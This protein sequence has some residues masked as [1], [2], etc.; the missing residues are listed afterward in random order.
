[1]KIQ[2]NAD[3]SDYS[4]GVAYAFSISEPVEDVDSFKLDLLN[5]IS[6]NEVN[7]EESFCRMVPNIASKN[8][9]TTVDCVLESAMDTSFEFTPIGPY[10]MVFLYAVDFKNNATII[11]YTFNPIAQ[12][13]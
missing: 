1:M 7:C 13:T 12:I 8:V 4:G 9:V 3:F 10:N 2:V 11:P 6:R 5:K